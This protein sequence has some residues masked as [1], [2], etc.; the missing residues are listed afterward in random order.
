MQDE[1]D[2]SEETDQ[3]KSPKVEV[4]PPETAASILRLLLDK[5]FYELQWCGLISDTNSNG[6]LAFNDDDD[7]EIVDEVIPWF[8]Y[9]PICRELEF[10]SPEEL[11]IHVR[12]HGHSDF[13]EYFAEDEDRERF[14][15]AAKDYDQK[16]AGKKSK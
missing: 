13:A 15:Q 3:S 5:T 11:V 6:W 2:Q 1:A 7:V 12:R 8:R 9:C 10:Y 16:K 4:C 14:I